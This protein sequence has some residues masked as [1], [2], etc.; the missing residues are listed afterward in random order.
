V[1]NENM[2]MRAGQ[3]ELSAAQMEHGKLYVG[4][5]DREVDTNSL[6]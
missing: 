6:G 5:I 1:N 3:L 2:A 4:I